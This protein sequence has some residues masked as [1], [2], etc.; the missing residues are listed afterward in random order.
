MPKFFFDFFDSGEVTPDNHGTD[1]HGIDA[2]KHE[3]AKTLGA[4]VGDMLPG[5]L[6]ELEIKIRDEADRSL[7]V[8]AVKFEMRANGL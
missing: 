1:L 3:A 8:V 6:R 5:S 4:I 7:G 2:A